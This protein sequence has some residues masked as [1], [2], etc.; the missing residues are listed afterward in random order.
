MGARD[1]GIVCGTSYRTGARLLKNFV[2]NKRLHLLTAP[3][4]RKPY[5]AF[6]YRLIEDGDT[7]NGEPHHE[8]KI[9]GS[10]R[11]KQLPHERS[12]RD[13]RPTNRSTRLL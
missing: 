12:V 9:P 8:E 7:T 5:H 3:D 2:T 1:A 13:M 4:E 10:H 6:D 11:I